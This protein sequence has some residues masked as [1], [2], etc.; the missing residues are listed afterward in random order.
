[1]RL[2]HKLT[3][4]ALLP[5][6]LIWAVGW[7]AAGVGERSLRDAIEQT[8]ATRA[9]AVMDE[10]DRAL[11][12]RISSWQAFCR[13]EL[14]RRTLEQSNTEF[15]E[16]PDRVTDID[17]DDLSWR[18][19][20]DATELPLIQQLL[21]NRLS[22]ELRSWLEKLE[23]SSEYPV[24]GEVFFTNKFGVNAA[25]S[26]RTED[27]NQAD[28][29]WWRQAV[30]DGLYVSDGNFDPSAGIYSI[31][32]CLRV[33][34]DD[35][36]MIG[37]LKAVMNIQEVF[38]IIDAR[39][40]DETAR[41]VLLRRDHRIIRVGNQDLPF[42]ADGSQ[43]FGDISIDP[44]TQTTTMERIDPETGE[45]VLCAYAFSRGYGGFEG[46][47]WVVVVQSEASDIFA[48]V[49]QL[50]WRVW[51]LS[52]LAILAT[53]AITGGI[54]WSLSSR[55]RRLVDATLAVGRGYLDMA[56]SEK[57]SDELAELAREFNRMAKKLSDYQQQLMA[58][59]RRAEAASEAK[60]T[61]LANMSHEI[62]TPMN[63]IVGMTQLLAKTELTEEQRDFLR[64]LHHS[65]DSL[66]RLLNDILDFSK[67][68]AGKLQLEEVD[69]SV[70]ECICRA[71]QSLS[72]SAAEKGIELACR[73]HPQVPDRLMG[74]PTRLRQVVMN[75]ASNAVKF[76]DQGEVVIEVEHEDLPDDRVRLN[77]EVRDTG[78]GI[79]PEVRD[80]LFEAFQ[81]AD[82]ST[83]R[84]YGGTGLGLAISARLV[85]MMG[86]EI[87]LQ[88]E[89]GN[90]TRVRFSVEMARGSETAESRTAH[91]DE[92]AGVPVLVVDDNQ[93]NRR[94][95]EEL[96]RY[97]R[98]EPV[99]ASHSE[100]ALELLQQAARKG[101]PFQLVLLDCMMP[102][103]D[104]FELAE[105]IRENAELGKPK[106]IM[107]SSAGRAGDARRARRLGISRYLIKPVLPS[108][109]LDTILVS[110]DNDTIRRIAHT[111]EAFKQ[112]PTLRTMRV[113]V[114]EDG[115]V[116]QRVALAFLKR[117]GHDVVLAT[118][119]K[120]A[121]EILERESIDV[122]LMDVQMPEM[123]GLTATR[124]IRERERETGEHVPIVAM[125]AAAMKGDCE[126]CLDAGM[127]AYLAKPL[128]ARELYRTIEQFFRNSSMPAGTDR[129]GEQGPEAFDLDS[130]C[131]RLGQDASA[132]A[133]TLQLLVS[134]CHILLEK[135]RLAINAGDAAELERAAHTLKHSAA[136]VDAHGVAQAAA[137]LEELGR[138]GDLSGIG[139]ALDRLEDEV[140]RLTAAL[141]TA[142]PS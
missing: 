129:E 91:L 95:L 61:F 94:I 74:D 40:A 39:S 131:R 59:K 64:M 135:M 5:A 30:S 16:Q 130:V 11:H 85:E 19:A 10:L 56:V 48:P 42:L 47:D 109:L 132:V 18:E 105:R 15:E 68:E 60:S 46:L 49:T 50:R 120:E 17:V 88:S 113:L 77:V 65:A 51:L 54:S 141:Q 2:M 27:Y 31:D 9:R 103:M 80:R 107:I 108:E 72:V 93:T 92:L 24:F 142:V 101:R 114:A 81:Q 21:D 133:E 58:A 136:E 53:T 33:D 86:G 89:P 99:S 34:D 45:P 35:G 44:S 118:N 3:L 104:G 126:R 67:I 1:M 87:D 28:E 78:V 111:K 84:K 20:A 98:F 6:L 121:I 70:R 23:E 36:Q 96:L 110:S 115:V 116:N 100:E 12:V 112:D 69:F 117:R 140:E 123:D 122:V 128:D 8:S 62:R 32:I 55:V 7:Y 57:G 139:E 71:G 22:R 43:Y 25:M 26:Q 127:D 75:L 90:G 38:N 76:T 82:A 124:L 63:G 106:M 134:E 41:V 52:I 29:L 66:L 14:V 102:E 79:A 73:I 125:T 13:T 97:W 138:S 119:G 4:V 37:V 83:T 137:Q